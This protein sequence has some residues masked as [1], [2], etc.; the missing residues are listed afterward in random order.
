MKLVTTCML[1]ALI[2]FPVACSD[3]GAPVAPAQEET[4]TSVTTPLIR[5]I[6][7]SSRGVLVPT[8]LAAA[9]DGTLYGLQGYGY[10][11]DH[12]D[13]AGNLLGSIPI[14][15]HVSGMD[16]DSDGNIH[17]QGDGWIRTLAP[18]GQV[19]SEF[20]YPYVP[21]SMESKSGIGGIAF[22]DAS[23]NTFALWYSSTSGDLREHVME[24]DP[25]G[26]VRSL[27]ESAASGFDLDGAGHLLALNPQ[28]RA[29]E[30]FDLRGRLLMSYP[31]PRDFTVDQATVSATPDAAIIVGYAGILLL[32]RH[33]GTFT[34]SGLDPDGLP[35]L[36]EVSK[37]C[38][39]PDSDFLIVDR[40]RYGVFRFSSTGAYLGAWGPRYPPGEFFRPYQLRALEDHS[41]LLWDFAS[42]RF[43]HLSASGT[44]LDSWGGRGYRLSQFLLPHFD[45]GPDGS[46]WVLQYSPLFPDPI[47]R[48]FQMNGT[49][50]THWEAAHGAGGIDVDGRGH[51][52][53]AADNAL[54]EYDAQGQLLRRV[55]GFSGFPFSHVGAF[56]VEDDGSMV[57]ADTGR[58][59]LVAADPDGQV[60]GNWGLEENVIGTRIGVDPQGR[61]YLW[62]DSQCVTVFSK[63]APR[64]V[65]KAKYFSGF[66]LDPEGRLWTIAV[67]WSL[68][69]Y[70]AIPADAAAPVVNRGS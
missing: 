35:Y 22:D 67:D 5:T 54:L 60:R 6:P 61:I 11:L 14:R 15:E 43:V 65:W 19:L 70:E 69:L 24:L 41:V 30:V 44:T 55:T 3:S 4:P 13:T 42:G 59:R 46:V 31:L 34:R 45:V 63:D 16:V 23:G 10:Q 53:V 49:L 29:L 36:M 64:A 18:S 20:S 48:R 40:G 62:T 38:V 37:P 21:P 66:D 2:V 58:H 8:E 9:P 47:V 12:L 27:W 56:T 32:D 33:S 28:H 52:W 39:L 50:M 1:L 57:V 7:A 25:A 51:P 26:N 68:R 17:L